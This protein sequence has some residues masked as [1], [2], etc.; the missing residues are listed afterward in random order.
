MSRTDSPFEIEMQNLFC[1]VS[2]K[3]GPVFEAALMSKKYEE[4]GSKEYSLYCNIMEK[5]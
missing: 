4:T 3:C 1:Q 2:R 5:A